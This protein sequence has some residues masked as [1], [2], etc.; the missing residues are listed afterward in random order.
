MWFYTAVFALLFIISVVREPRRMRCAVFLLAALLN[1]VWCLLGLLSGGT[2]LNDQQLYILIAALALVFLVIA[3]L[4]VVLILNGFV[5]VR[6][7]GTGVAHLLGLFLGLIILGY[8]GLSVLAVLRSD[9]QLMMWVLFMGVPL[10]YLGFGFTAYVLYSS[11]YLAVTKRWAKPPSAVLVLGA[12]LIRNKVSRLLA[13]RLDTGLA[14]A[15]RA[16]ASG[17]DPV[18]VVSGGQGS[19]E[20]RSEASAM[21][22]YLDDL[23]TEPRVL[24]EDQ[25]TTTKENIAF[26]QALLAESGI[27]G[28]VAVVTNNFHAFRAALLARRAGL[29]GYAVGAP[30]AHYFWPSAT[31]REF[32]AIML[33]YRVFTI[34]CLSLSLVPLLILLV[35]PILL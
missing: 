2:D 31:I 3:G 16:I 18:I 1:V 27:T 17:Q 13:N 25:S 23:G 20:P 8:I 7:E 22:E 15:R 9:L 35:T 32:V 4:G 24:L 6:R 5:M 29:P 14:L 19:D 28:Q 33:D 12:G 30:T 26:S 10:A 21:A 34:V 11:C